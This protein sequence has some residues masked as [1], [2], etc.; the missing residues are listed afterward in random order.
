METEKIN[1]IPKIIHYCWYGKKRKPKLVRDCIKSWKKHLP[2]YEIIE[3]NE[4][5]SDLSHPFVKEAYRLEKWAFIADYIRLKVLYDNGG[6]YLDTDMMLLSSLNDFLNNECFF[7][8]E[9]KVI[10]G[11]AIIGALR[12]NEF[13]KEFLHCYDFINIDEG[14]DWHENVNTIM[15]TKLFKSRFGFSDS[16][17]KKISYNAI[18]VYPI[19]TFYPFPFAEKKDVLNYK[20]YIQEESCGVHLWVGSW[21]VYN[22]FKFLRNGEYREGFKIIYKKGIFKNLN[23]KYFRKAL[24]AIKESLAK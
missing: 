14:V 4:K 11:T 12:N 9:D 3:W 5:N 22:E 10:I 17:V 18:V 1:V 20:M 2:D 13:I 15:V 7:G 19:S 24:S 6:I 23:F 21:I 16:F 8:A